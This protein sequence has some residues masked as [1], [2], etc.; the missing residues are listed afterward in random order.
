M[1]IITIDNV[2]LAEKLAPLISILGSL[3]LVFLIFTALNL[4]ISIYEDNKKRK[5]LQEA[6]QLYTARKRKFEG[7]EKGWKI[8]RDTNYKITDLVEAATYY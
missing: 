2:A 4:V 3:L 1:T 7:D 5:R 8:W 6:K